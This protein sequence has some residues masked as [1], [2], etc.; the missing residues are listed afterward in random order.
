[1]SVFGRKQ[2]LILPGKS[3]VIFT[4]SRQSLVDLLRYSKLR[5]TFFSATFDES[6]TSLLWFF[7]DK[8]VFWVSV[9]IRNILSIHFHQ[10]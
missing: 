6:H 9:P 7:L 3:V 1:M 2:T 10:Y 8:A 5:H 4:F